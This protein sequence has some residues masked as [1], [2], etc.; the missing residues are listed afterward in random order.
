ML[1]QRLDIDFFMYGL[2]STFYP[3]SFSPHDIGAIFANL[4]ICGNGVGTD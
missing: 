4:L 3:L 1:V 2:L